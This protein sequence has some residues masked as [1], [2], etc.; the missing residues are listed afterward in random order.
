[1]TSDRPLVSVIIPFYNRIGLLPRALESVIG[2]T[3]KELEIILVDDGSTD[4]VGPILS[5]FKDGRIR[6]VRHDV[7]RGVSAA[8]N[9]GI[10][11]A[12]GDYIS[13]LDSDDEW[14]PTKAERQVA[15]LVGGRGEFEVSYCFSD[16]VSDVTN[17]L[18]GRHNFEE[19][20]NILHHALIGTIAQEGGNCLC[21]LVNS[22]MLAKE[23]MLRVGG[24]DET[25]RKHEDWE[26][27]VRLAEKYRFGCVKETLV[28][29]HKHDQGHVDKDFRDVPSVRYYIM[30]KHKK[31]YRADRLALAHFYSELAYYEGLCGMRGRALFSIC[32]SMANRPFQRDPYIKLYLLMTNGWDKPRME[33]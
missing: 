3:Y 14:L 23:E 29:N 33:F 31:S 4:D 6:Y 7:N 24:F 1:M 17:K 10:K 20:G 16:V 25:M 26:L 30:E 11:A 5:E 2:Q 32:R 28:R 21:I 9:S 27:L 15:S 12:V 19:E 18:I 8:R 13:F 22:L